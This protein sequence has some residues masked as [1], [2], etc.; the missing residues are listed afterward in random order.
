MDSIFSY[1]KN[2]QNGKLIGVIGIIF[3]LLSVYYVIEYLGKDEV[4]TFKPGSIEMKQVSGTDETIL[5]DKDQQLELYIKEEQDRAKEQDFYLKSAYYLNDNDKRNFDGKKLNDNDLELNI[6]NKKKNNEKEEIKIE[7]KE[8]IITENN[9]LN[10]A[11]LDRKRLEDERIK[12]EKEIKNSLIDDILNCNKNC[13]LDCN[14]ECFQNNQDRTELMKLNIQKL[15]E[16]LKKCKDKNTECKNNK[17]KNNDIDIWNTKP[18]FTEMDPE[19]LSAYKKNKMQLLSNLSSN[20]LYINTSVTKNVKKPLIETEDIK[21]EDSGYLS[22]V[23]ILPGSSFYGTLQNNLNSLSANNVA[24]I[25]FTSPQLKGFKAIGES[26]PDANNESM[27]ISIK[28]IIDPNGNRIQ[29]N[30][31][32]I[33]EKKMSSTLVDEMDTKTIKRIG[34]TSASIILNAFGSAKTTA[35]ASGGTQSSTQAGILSTTP[36]QDFDEL[37]VG[38][39]ASKTGENIDNYLV[40]EL[41]KTQNEVKVNA[42][43]E[44]IVIFY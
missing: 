28:Q 27:S 9:D 32:A 31:F 25:Q 16:F 1:I 12:R 23:K 38:N 40:Q 33:D 42:G 44:L 17:N 14:Q 13:V 35:Q 39:M 22:N 10:Q 4:E 26:K 24:I 15:E 18:N 30:A 2:S 34:L 19:A 3:I 37:F 6:V 5:I 29:V 11:E 41:Q 8:K 7:D 20:N 43:K 36:R 21:E